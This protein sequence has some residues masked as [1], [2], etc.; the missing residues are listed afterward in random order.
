MLNAS[1]YLL[2]MYLRI[3]LYT[4]LFLLFPNCALGTLLIKPV[5]NRP[6]TPSPPG[7]KMTIEVTPSSPTHLDTNPFRTSD[8]PSPMPSP[9]LKHRGDSSMLGGA[10]AMEV[11]TNISK[12]KSLVSATTCTYC[13]V[14]NV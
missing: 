11:Q 8:T 2:C 1:A 5:N 3:H 6:L 9:V 7:P 4:I 10:S 14:D 13:L 12:A